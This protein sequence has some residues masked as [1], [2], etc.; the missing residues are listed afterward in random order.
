MIQRLWKLRF[1]KKNKD[2]DAWVEIEEAW[3]GA[4]GDF[5]IDKS[6]G[7]ITLF[8]AVEKS[9]CASEREEKMTVFRK[10]LV[11]A[12]WSL[13]QTGEQDVNWFRSLRDLAEYAEGV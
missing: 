3:C 2:R 9:D 1:G 10:G 4:D 8:I 5:E 13:W 7:T 6:R 12:S 11:G